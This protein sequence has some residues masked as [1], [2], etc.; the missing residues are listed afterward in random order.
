[1]RAFA[2]GFVSLLLPVY[3]LSLGF[4]GLQIGALATATLIGSAVL[5]LLVGFIATAFEPALYSLLP[6]C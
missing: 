3:L 4:D 2:D 6:P 1:V 5:A